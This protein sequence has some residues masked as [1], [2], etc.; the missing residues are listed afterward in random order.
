MGRAD[1]TER[2]RP[3]D[4]SR[5]PTTREEAEAAER[6]GRRL[7]FLFFWGSSGDHRPSADGTPGPA[8]LSQ[9]WEAPF[10]ADGHTFPTAEHH[11]MAH[12]AWLFGDGETAE[13]VLAARHPGEAK[14]LGRAVRGFD[15]EEWRRRRRGIVV[16]G[17]LAK[18][19][20]R[21]DLRSYLL[22]TRH[23]V[24]VEASP[25]DRVWGIGLTAD[26]PDAGS[27]A[28]WR[29]ANLLGFALM[30]VRTALSQRGA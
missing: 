13:R 20:A 30:D 1:G 12:K 11:M 2:A 27:P 29:G 17:N 4:A 16:C 23:R 9:W 10:T 26:D 18:F 3:G 22:A 8:C 24:L 15:E 6:D 7:R 28:A 25:L 5:L 14:R 19:G 21:A